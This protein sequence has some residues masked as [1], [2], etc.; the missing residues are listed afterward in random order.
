MDLVEEMACREPLCAKVLALSTR[1]SNDPNLAERY[2]AMGKDS[3]VV[4]VIHI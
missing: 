1:A 3:S 2:E 4:S